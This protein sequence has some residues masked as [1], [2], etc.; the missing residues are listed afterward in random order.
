MPDNSGG[1][2]VRFNKNRL[3]DFQSLKEKQHPRLKFTT[4]RTKYFTEANVQNK[5]KTPYQETNGTQE[6]LDTF[7]LTW[8]L[9]LLGCIIL[10]RKPNSTGKAPSLSEV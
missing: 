9:L 10:E 7:M 8:S 2:A 4:H 6:H 3:H 1:C 5:T